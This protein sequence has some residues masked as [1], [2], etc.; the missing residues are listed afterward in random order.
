MGS[1]LDPCQTRKPGQAAGPGLDQSAESSTRES[2]VTDRF[3]LRGVEL[4]KAASPWSPWTM[5]RALW[6]RL[7]L[8]LREGAHGRGKGIFRP[9]GQAMD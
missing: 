8:S 1:F 9:L 2:L 6:R 3:P 7:R 4:V 5:R